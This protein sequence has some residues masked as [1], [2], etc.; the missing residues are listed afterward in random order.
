MG[1]LQIPVISHPSGFIPFKKSNFCISSSK[2]FLSYNESLFH[3]LVYVSF[4]KDTA[5][6]QTELES[7][8]AVSRRNNPAR[9][10]TG[11]LL[12]RSG[13]FI[14]TLVERDIE[15]RM[16]PDWSMGYED[17]DENSFEAINTLLLWTKKIK[18]SEGAGRVV[19]TRFLKSFLED[20][21]KI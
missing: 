19:V 6:I 12:Y 15:E 17:V 14:Q 5:N 8:L 7:I 20:F 1:W 2:S 13:V 18:S 10:I 4:A 16:F 9:E 21:S 3:Q 11:L